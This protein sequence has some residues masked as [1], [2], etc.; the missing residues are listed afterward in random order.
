MLPGNTQEPATSD[1]LQQLHYL[2]CVI[3]E[4]LRIFP[5]V[6]FIARILDEDCILGEMLS[7]IAK[8]KS[9]SPKCFCY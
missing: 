9:N 7:A 3:K 2:T 1:Q 8:K 5:S 6:P 4:T